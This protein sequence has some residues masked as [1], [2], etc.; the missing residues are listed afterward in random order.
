MLTRLI[1]SLD[2]EE[3]TTR[4]P[5]IA[6]GV[7]NVSPFLAGEYSKARFQKAVVQCYSNPQ[8]SVRKSTVFCLVAMVNK[9]GREPVNPYLSSLS[10]S[11]VSSDSCSFGFIYH[12]GGPF[13]CSMVVRLFECVRQRYIYS[14]RFLAIGFKPLFSSFYSSSL[15]SFFSSIVLGIAEKSVPWLSLQSAFCR[16]RIRKAKAFFKISSVCS[17]CLE[18]D[19]RI[20]LQ[21]E[22]VYFSLCSGASYWLVGQLEHIGINNSSILQYDTYNKYL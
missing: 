3:L 9:L 14:R 6:P 7:V 2:A 12:F 20:N 22:W 8:S 4:L 21:K 11:K 18:R 13:L 10:N 5:E 1:E 19:K 16:Q 15:V 17:E